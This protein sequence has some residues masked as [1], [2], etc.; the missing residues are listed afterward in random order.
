MTSYQLNLKLRIVV[1]DFQAAKHKLHQRRICAILRG[2][3]PHP[4]PKLQQLKHTQTNVGLKC[5]QICNPCSYLHFILRGNSICKFYHRSRF[6][7]FYLFYLKL[8]ETNLSSTLLYLR[9]YALYDSIDEF[10][11][12][13][14]N[15]LQILGDMTIGTMCLGRVDG[16][17]NRAMVIAI[18]CNP[19]RDIMVT[20]FFVD[21][22]KSYVLPMADLL[23][24]PEYLVEK[25]PFQVNYFVSSNVLFNN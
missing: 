23:A 8:H 12:E 6:I 18:D 2:N 19:D 21:L 24:I 4:N 22:G 9:L 17:Y 16:K 3:Q 1:D 14:S 11:L 5:S 25:E 13:E 10:T 7:I 15:H 20:V